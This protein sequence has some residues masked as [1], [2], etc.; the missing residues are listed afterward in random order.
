MIDNAQEYALSAEAMKW[1]WK[2]FINV[3]E[4]LENPY[5][6][7]MAAKDFSNLPSTYLITADLDPLRDQG[8]ELSKQLEIAGNTVI[9]KNYPSLI[10]G[11]LLMQGFLPEA[12][13]AV[14][15]IAEVV[16]QFLNKSE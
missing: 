4:D 11:S 12:Q 14:K 13:R 3:A 7:P 1:Y 5:C 8:L 16:K 9:Y 6:R 10:H 2:Q 15:E